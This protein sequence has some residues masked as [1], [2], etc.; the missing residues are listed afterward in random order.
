MKD[1]TIKHDNCTVTVHIPDAI[2]YE[3][4]KN[5]T[6]KFMLGVIRENEVIRTPSKSA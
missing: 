3:N 4:L 6:I 1:K 5:A 2:N